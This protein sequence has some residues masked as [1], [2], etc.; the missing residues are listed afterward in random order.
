MP[1]SPQAGETRGRTLRAF[2]ERILHSA[3]PPSIGASLLLGSCLP[4][5]FGPWQRHDMCNQLF[6]VP[7]M[8]SGN[9]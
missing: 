3:F 6:D 7:G 1:T 4:I 2:Q 8:Y 9:I 5:G